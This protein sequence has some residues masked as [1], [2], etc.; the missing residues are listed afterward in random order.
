MAAVRQD[1]RQL[2]FAA[3]ELRA[4]R[5]VIFCAVKNYG[6]AL[7]H[8]AP[9][10]WDHEVVLEAVTTVGRV[11]PNSSSPMLDRAAKMELWKNPKVQQ[12]CDDRDFILLAV[13]QDPANLQFASDALRADREVVIRALN[14]DVYALEYAASSLQADREIVMKAILQNPASLKFAAPVLK[15]DRALVL[16]AVEKNGMAYKFASPKLQKDQEI[17]VAA[18]KA[19]CPGALLGSAGVL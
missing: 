6:H 3:A 19:N 5:D 16:M 14:K 9:D 8:A 15:D 11:L 2:E 4:D 13:E 12:M 18:M 17:L 7:L 10:C 1:G